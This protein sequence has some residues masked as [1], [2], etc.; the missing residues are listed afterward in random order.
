[1]SQAEA[2]TSRWVGGELLVGFRAGVGPGERHALFRRHG[3]DFLA[4]V[5]Q[6]IRI[7]RIR[8]APGTEDA[9][10]S[11][12][13]AMPQVKFV[14]KNYEFRPS[15]VP[16][17]P[18]YAGQ[19]H[20]PRINAPAAWDLTQGGAGAVIAILDS[21]ID[22]TVTEF[23]GKL[24]AGTNT[25]DSATP[26]DTSDAF[27]HGT[28]VAGI[29]GA[30]TNN[31]IGIAGVAGASPLMP[32]RVTN[33]TGGAT[34][35]SIANGILWAADHG[36]R[37]V[38]LSFDGVAGNATIRAAAEYAYNHGTLVVAAAGNCG[39]TDA[40]AE[41]PFI[42]SVSATDM[43]DAVAFYSSTGPYVDIAA[44]G[45]N[46]VTTEKGGIYLPESG[47]SMASPVVAGVASLMF[48]ANANMTPA[49]VTQLIESTAVDVGGNGVDPAYGHGRVDAFAAVQAASLYQPPAD[50]TPPAVQL[51]SP[52]DQ[53]KV[54]GVVVIA[55]TAT[56]N[57]GVA[58][59]DLYVD[60]GY[61]DSD[62]SSPY[63]FAWDTGALADGAHTLQVIAFDAAGNSTGTSPVTVTVA[64][65]KPD[66]TPPTA[67]IGSPAAGASVSG[68]VAVHAQ[69]ADDV[70]VQAVAFYVDGTLRATVTVLPYD[71]SW[72]TT[73]L[74][75][76]A[77]TLQV[78]A[79]DAAG[80]TRSASLAL[81]VANTVAQ[82]PVAR[83][84]AL[85]SPMRLQSPYVAQ[86]LRVLANDS[87]ADGDLDPASV[88]V[89]QG[90]DQGSLATVRSD[91]SISYV[92]RQGFRGVET[93][94]YTVNDRRGSSS[95]AA[96]VTLTVFGIPPRHG[97][98]R[99]GR[100]IRG[101]GNLP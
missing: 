80:N 53:Q 96:M 23:G 70:G 46:L 37:V 34:S 55:V 86:V 66:V 33:A 10:R 84:D 12:L 27:G 74:A 81:T 67:S 54:S 35:A 7:A 94:R 61:F 18:E 87:D 64:N 78:T 83:D 100:N 63:S 48:A 91:G 17:D 97:A 92:P 57:I 72:D 16:N 47:T 58:K 65:A 88:R 98:E 95:N 42:L 49:L 77:H 38:N 8:V 75:N 62:A 4:D 39:C 89:T 25:F 85:Q 60:G 22:A 32:V 14:E 59:V 13:E 52:A 68:T 24:V 36:A 6:Q 1:M 43:A 73:G 90:P 9:L 99:D 44:P 41:N 71:W 29:A 5:G 2:G 51:T 28:E 19:W 50:A 15:A 20:L 11:R 31:G 76:G 56:D 93:F 101:R 82:A 21:G 45:D 40:T 30:L 26:G 3:A 79:S 69:A